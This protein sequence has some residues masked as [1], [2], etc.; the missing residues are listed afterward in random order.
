MLTITGPMTDY[1]YSAPWY[2]TENRDHVKTIAI[3]DGCTYIGETA[4]SQLANLTSVTLPA[5]AARLGR[6]CFLHDRSLTEVIIPDVVSVG[7]FCF[8]DCSAL[9]KVTLSP[10]TASIG[11]YAFDGCNKL[12]SLYLPSGITF[13]A[14][15]NKYSGI[16]FFFSKNADY[17]VGRCDEIGLRC[18]LTDTAEEAVALPAGLRSIETGAFEGTAV[19]EYRIPAGCTAVG[20]RAFASLPDGTVIVFMGRDAEIA[21]DAFDKGA[22]MLSEDFLPDGVPHSIPSER[23][24]L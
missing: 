19:Q 2:C 17:L 21:L 7:D 12:H 18:F 15:M 22:A 6:E 16:T 24:E 11:R 8:Q 23:E 1:G 3:E 20:N 9:T 4:F 14:S 5:S 10:A 13:L